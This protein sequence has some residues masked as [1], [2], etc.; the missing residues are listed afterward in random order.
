M[1]MENFEGKSVS[2]R[3]TILEG[4]IVTVWITCGSIDLTREVLKLLEGNLKSQKIIR[5]WTFELIRKQTDEDGPK[6]RVIVKV[7]YN[8]FEKIPEIQEVP[9]RST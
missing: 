9:F 7:T 5:G 8:L 6:G 3:R 1:S 4:T 2:E